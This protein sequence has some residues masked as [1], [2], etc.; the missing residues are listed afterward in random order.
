MRNYLCVC[1]YICICIY[2][3]IYAQCKCSESIMR[4]F[5]TQ[6]PPRSQLGSRTQGNGGIRYNRERLQCDP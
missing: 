1:M 5:H 2:I 4:A 6:S 3:Y